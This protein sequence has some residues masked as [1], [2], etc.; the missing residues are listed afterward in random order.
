MHRW[1]RFTVERC[2]EHGTLVDGPDH[3]WDVIDRTTGHVV[4]NANTRDEARLEAHNR[5]SE[6]ILARFRTQEAA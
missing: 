3:T 6:T 4:F 2:D 1:R 5:E